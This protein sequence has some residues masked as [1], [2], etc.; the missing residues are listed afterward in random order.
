MK[1][2]VNADWRLSWTGVSYGTLDV[3]L[4]R[5]LERRNSNGPRWKGRYGH[6]PLTT[7]VGTTRLGTGRSFSSGHYR[8]LVNRKG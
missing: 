1:G 4:M 6:T 5:M 3:G 7:A 8:T 2:G